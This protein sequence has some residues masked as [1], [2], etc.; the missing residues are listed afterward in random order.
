MNTSLYKRSRFMYICEAALEY[1][2]SILVAGTYL[3]LITKELG[4][5]DTLTGIISSF[6]SL[7]CVFQLFAMLL[8]KGNTKK[9]VLFL[10]VLNQLLFMS[11]YIIPLTSGSKDVKT[12]LFIVVILLAYF[13]Y[14]VAHPKKIDWFMSLVDYEKRGVFTAK[15]E[16]VSLIAGMTFSFIMG[17]V[18]DHYREIGEIRTAF[19]ICAIVIFVLMLL[20]TASMIFTIEKPGDSAEATQKSDLLSVLK[21]KNIIRITI[22]FVLWNIA[23]YCATPYYGTYQI[24]EL[25][26]SQRFVAILSVVYAVARVS[27][28]FLLGKYADKNSFA[29]MLRLCFLVAALGFLINAFCVPENGKIVYTLFYICN[30]IAMG[31]INSALINLCYDYV[32]EKKRADAL[33]ISLAIAGVCGF[34]STLAVSPLVTHIQNNGNTFLGMPL[35]AQQ[36]L[37]VIAFTATLVTALYVSIFLIK[38][39]KISESDT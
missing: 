10:S 5:S 19:I 29:K 7:G 6:I 3:A 13:F 17:A 9:K 1:L 31:G 37:S 15:K 35:Y 27:F 28:S 14:N 30:A 26:F 16:M 36:V 25:G 12:A 21:D 18:A 33:A 4:I 22:V 34:F 2:I 20:H 11:L 38:I 8:R 32:E 23:T 39:K 24:G